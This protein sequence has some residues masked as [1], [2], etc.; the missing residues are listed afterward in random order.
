MLHQRCRVASVQWS[1]ALISHST[2]LHLPESLRSQWRR[3]TGSSNC[4]H[5]TLLPTTPALRQLDGR[6]PGLHKAR[7]TVAASMR[8]SSNLRS[9]FR[10]I[11][12]RKLPGSL[13]DARELAWRVPEMP[14]RAIQ[15]S[16]RPEADTP[17]RVARR[18]PCA[19]L[20]NGVMIVRYTMGNACFAAHLGTALRRTLPSHFLFQRPRLPRVVSALPPSCLIE[21]GRCA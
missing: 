18:L 9:R 12:P 10:W 17:C 11:G 8:D 4:R 15:A 20:V 7:R 21:L 3:T 2:V 6:C 19:V 16:W 5:P 14:H 13:R 1:S